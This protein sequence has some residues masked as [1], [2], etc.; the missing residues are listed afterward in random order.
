MLTYIFFMEKRICCPLFEPTT[1]LLNVAPK[2]TLLQWVLT[3]ELNYRRLQPKLS[4][5][6]LKCVFVNII[7]TYYYYKEFILA[8]C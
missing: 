2:L 6:V 8:Y 4:F 3:T 5:C 1:F 7:I